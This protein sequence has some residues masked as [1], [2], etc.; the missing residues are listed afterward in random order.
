MFVHEISSWY[1]RREYTTEQ[2]RREMCVWL[3][4][5]ITA[6]KLCLYS[7]KLLFSEERLWNSG[8][9]LTVPFKF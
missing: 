2:I 9:K 3:Q 6:L 1:V 8:H 4:A 7:S 5:N